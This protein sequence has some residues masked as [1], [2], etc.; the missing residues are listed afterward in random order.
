MDQPC[1]N[2]AK[3]REERD[4][5]LN[6]LAVEREKVNAILLSQK[7]PE[8][9]PPKPIRYWAVDVINDG[10]KRVMPWPHKGVRALIG[11]LRR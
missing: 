5:A 8:P 7:L 9:P 11:A 6:A 4:A 1:P 3:M 10:L 2:C